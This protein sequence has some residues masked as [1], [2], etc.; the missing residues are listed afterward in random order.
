MTMQTKKIMRFHREKLSLETID[1]Q[2]DDFPKRLENI[3]KEIEIQ[4]EGINR[5]DSDEQYNSY[6]TEFNKRLKDCVEQRIGIKIYFI[7]SAVDIMQ[8]KYPSWYLNSPINFLDIKKLNLRD[9]LEMRKTH[10]KANNKKIIIDTKKAYIK[11]DLINITESQNGYHKILYSPVILMKDLKITPKEMAAG[12]LHEIGHI[13]TYYEYMNRLETTN[14]ILADIASNLSNKQDKREYVFVELLQNKVIGQ[15]DYDYLIKNSGTFLLGNN[16]FSIVY[17]NLSSQLP[18]TVYSKTMNETLADAF[19]TR[20]GMGREII[21]FLDKT[22]DESTLS[23]L[24]WL[25]WGSIAD[26]SWLSMTISLISLAIETSGGFIFQA[27]MLYLI[28]IWMIVIAFFMTDSKK[29]WTYDTIL[30]R[31]KRIRNQTV[32]YLKN[33][34]LDKKDIKNTLENLEAMDTIINNTYGYKSFLTTIFNFIF[35]NNRNIGND[36]E[37]QRLL[38]QLSSNDL[39]ISSAKFRTLI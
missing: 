32:E 20:F 25:F 34:N 10:S 22:G 3:F 39:F 1:F 7:C 14:E 18:N 38:E 11:G 26:L 37:Y 15:K 6:F 12:V 23:S 17:K 33:P 2:T 9:V 35:S 16:L 13:F 5:I 27:P 21:T 19:A 31:Y 8:S 30:Y 28:S 29:D 24:I 36:I 4:C